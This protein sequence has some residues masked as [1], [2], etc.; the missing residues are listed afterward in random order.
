MVAKRSEILGTS[1]LPSFLPMVPQWKFWNDIKETVVDSYSV[2]ALFISR[3][4]STRTVSWHSSYRGS[5]QLVQYP[6]TLHIAGEGLGMW[7]A[8]LIDSA[9]RQYS[10]VANTHVFNP[11]G[12]F[13]SR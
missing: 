12:S 7:Y 13:D 8:I 10:I 4:R 9:P 2:L 11:L 3:V 5:G 1:S 6:N